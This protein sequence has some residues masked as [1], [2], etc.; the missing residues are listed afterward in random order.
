VSDK[1]LDKLVSAMNDGRLLNLS[2]QVL[3]PLLTRHMDDR[4]LQM[5]AKFR[6]GQKEFIGDVAAISYIQELVSEL[7]NKQ[8]KGNQAR[9][10]L[11]HGSSR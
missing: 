3:F 1:N 10:K 4:V 7:K 6:E 2:E 11:E 8:T 9:E 5:C